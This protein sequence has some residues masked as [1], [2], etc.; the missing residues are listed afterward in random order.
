[1]STKKLLNIAE[2]FEKLT[3]K[4]QHPYQ[5][6]STLNDSAHHL[7][8]M[9]QLFE[10]AALGSYDPDDIYEEDTDAPKKAKKAKNTISHI[11]NITAYIKHKAYNEGMS[12][13]DAVFYK[14]KITKL[15]NELKDLPD[16]ASQR[17]TPLMVTAL[18]NFEKRINDWMTYG[19]PP[20][21]IP[22]PKPAP[23]APHYK[24]QM[25][26]ER[27]YHPP[28]SHPESEGAS[29]DVLDELYGELYKDLRRD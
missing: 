15:F 24:A 7:Q 9:S 14:A 8:L 21:V 19:F 25:S 2:N 13:S 20:V 22:A 17:I 4:G 10:T 27:Q 16:K 5:Q 18:T 3:S 1:M 28:M 6:I 11:N 23:I 12:G 29:G 26:G